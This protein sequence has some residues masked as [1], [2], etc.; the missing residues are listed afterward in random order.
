MNDERRLELETRL[1]HLSEKIMN[2]SFYLSA[3]E[4]NSEKEIQRR[5]ANACGDALK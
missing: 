1:V 4:I 3:R 2:L 5:L